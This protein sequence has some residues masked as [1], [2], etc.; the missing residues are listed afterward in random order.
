M[1]ARA[2]THRPAQTNARRHTPEEQDRQARRA[3]NTGSTRWRRLR[4][5]VLARDLYQCRRCGQH[6]NQ[7]DHVDGDAS[8]NDLDNLQV[9]CASCHS[10]KTAIENSGFGNPR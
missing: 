4:A 6:G 8:R 5:Q 1:P 3:L 2:P 10:R 7:V 9:L